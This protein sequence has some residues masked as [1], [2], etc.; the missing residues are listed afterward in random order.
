MLH[1]SNVH[2]EIDGKP[3]LNGL[4]LSVGAGEAH[5]IMGPN[6]AGKLTLGSVLGQGER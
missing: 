6:G 3:I 5:A 1:I 2:A 4:S